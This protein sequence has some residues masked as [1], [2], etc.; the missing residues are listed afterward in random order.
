MLHAELTKQA[1]SQTSR[2]AYDGHGYLLLPDGNN[3]MQTITAR[4]L[5]FQEAEIPPKYEDIPLIDN[6][7]MTKTEEKEPIKEKS[8]ERIETQKTEDG[9]KVGLFS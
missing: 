5:Y 8:P 9:D 7:E 6:E 2:T 1:V 4:Q 3:A